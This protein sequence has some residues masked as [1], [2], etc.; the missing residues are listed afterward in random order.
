MVLLNDEVYELMKMNVTITT[1]NADSADDCE[2]VEIS[3]V[4]NSSL[5][6]EALPKKKK[7]IMSIEK[8]L[9]KQVD[10]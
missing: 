6:V 10:V 4:E 8:V 1:A 5:A 3:D 2:V 9:G 7:K